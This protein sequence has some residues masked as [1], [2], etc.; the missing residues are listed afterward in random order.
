[1]TDTQH[2]KLTQAELLEEARARFGDDPL[3]WAFICPSCRDV[4]TGQDFQQALAAN[5]RKHTTGQDVSATDI[6]G[7]ECIGRS[8]GALDK[9]QTYTG[10]GCTFVAYGLIPGPW[11]VALSNGRTMRTF[12]LARAPEK[13]IPAVSIGIAVGDQG[14]AFTPNSQTSSAMTPGVEP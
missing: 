4:A 9:R 11:E 6:V 1:M 13:D 2:R 10:R 8:L 3:Q 5:P 12:P 14:T 7:Q